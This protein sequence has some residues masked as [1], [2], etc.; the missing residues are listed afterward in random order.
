VEIKAGHTVG[1]QKGGDV[2][3]AIIAKLIVGLE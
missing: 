2:L 3:F 1:I